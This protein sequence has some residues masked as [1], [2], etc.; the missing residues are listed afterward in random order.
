MELVSL[1]TGNIRDLMP[2]GWAP[3]RAVNPRMDDAPDV[4]VVP[5]SMDTPPQ[6]QAV[7]VMVPPRLQ[8]NVVELDSRLVHLNEE[9]FQLDESEFQSLLD[10]IA[11][12]YERHL[13]NKLSALRGMYNVRE[14]SPR[15][16]QEVPPLPVAA[17][18][19]EE[20]SGPLPQMRRAGK[21]G[22]R[23]VQQVHRE[24]AGSSAPPPDPRHPASHPDVGLG[25]GA[26]GPMFDIGAF[27]ARPL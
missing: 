6:A 18:A 16:V 17:P 12:A 20:A 9:L 15:P 11:L 5:R 1:G 27:T 22:T 19:S 25:G 3:S 7:P 2:T 10:I 4:P 23:Q 8:P 13:R 26:D 21:K 14:A 24:E